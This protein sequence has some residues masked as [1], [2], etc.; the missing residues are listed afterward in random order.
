MQF[1]AVDVEPYLGP[2]V[3]RAEA[4]DQAPKS[5]GMIHLDEV[6]HFVRREIVKHEARRKDEPPRI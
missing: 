4:L 1:A 3:I 6:R 5:H 2:F